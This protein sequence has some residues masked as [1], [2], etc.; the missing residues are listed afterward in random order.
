MIQ[1]KKYL[2]ALCDNSKVRNSAFAAIPSGARRLAQGLVPH[3]VRASFCLARELTDALTEAVAES[4]VGP[5][6]KSVSCG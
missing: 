3:T 6:R 5:A 2:M 1:I 4:A